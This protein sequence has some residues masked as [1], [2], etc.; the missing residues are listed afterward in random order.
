LTV[1]VAWSD[2]VALP[3]SAI[4]DAGVTMVRF[5]TV[6]VLGHE[7]T[8][9]M[10]VDAPRS[11]HAAPQTPQLLALD[12]RSTHA[13]LHKVWAPVHPLI[14]VPLLHDIPDPQT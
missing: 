12:D 14:H 1:A 9:F 4:G 7:Q 10:H 11:E 2:N 5:V 6:A 8:L 3:S 13:P